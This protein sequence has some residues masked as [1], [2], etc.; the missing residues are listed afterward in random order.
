M[1]ASVLKV[2][3]R[4]GYTIKVLS[5]LLQG[6]LKDSCF[7]INEKGIRLVGVD[8]LT[9]T[10]TVLLDL[11]LKSTN[12]L[13]FSLTHPDKRICIG[14]NLLHLYK[15][16]KPIRKKDF[17]TLLIDK[18]RTSELGIKIEPNGENGSSISYLAITNVNPVEV[19]IP[20]GYNE[21]VKTTSK[22]FQKL[23]TLNKM[24]KQIKVVFNGSVI[25][26]FAGKE[27]LW[28][29]QIN[30]G[31]SDE[32]DDSSRE[33]KILYSQTFEARKI[34]QLVKMAGLSN[35]IQIY[36]GQ[37][38]PLKFELNVGTLGKICIYLKSQEQIEAEKRE[39]EENPGNGPK[40]N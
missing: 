3:T 24:S 34:I 26:F 16:L 35:I 39:E 31:E 11:D 6:Y 17:L 10:G 22:E 8:T 12:F 2:K 13:P 32:S 38:L 18:E 15:M 28:S 5:E 4:E 14:M 23:K 20:E 21:P 30:L 29:R 27:N 7:S 40:E 19:D 36:T 1:M 25:S 9:R 33:K 37:D